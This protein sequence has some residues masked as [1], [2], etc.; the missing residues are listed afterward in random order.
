MCLTISHVTCSMYSV[1]QI[2]R[3]QYFVDRFRGN[4][5]QK[6]HFTGFATDIGSK[7]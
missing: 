2:D 4:V 5:S 3:N 6:E 7:L 1:N